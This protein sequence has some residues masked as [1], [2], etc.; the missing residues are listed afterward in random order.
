MLRARRGRKRARDEA[1]PASAGEA[2]SDTDI[3]VFGAL[4]GTKNDAGGLSQG[5]SDEEALQSFI[6]DSIVKRNVKGGTKVLKQAK[7]NAKMM[8]GEVGGGSFQSMGAWFVFF[9]SLVHDAM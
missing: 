6:H 8:K 3:D 4:T 9:C 5:N 1:D 7:G 2:V